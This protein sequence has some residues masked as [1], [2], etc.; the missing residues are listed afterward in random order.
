[1]SMPLFQVQTGKDLRSSVLTER[2]RELNIMLARPFT[3]IL[4][5]YGAFE[6]SD[7][8]DVSDTPPAVFQIGAGTLM[9]HV[10]KT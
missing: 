5:C 8:N 4:S 10:F 2:E 3:P 1:M 6:Q 9:C 7:N